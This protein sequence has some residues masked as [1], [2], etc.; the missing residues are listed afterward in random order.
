MSIVDEYREYAAECLK[1]AKVAKSECQRDTYLE[2]ASVWLQAAI[3]AD[4]RN[5]D[6][7]QISG[8][9]KTEAISR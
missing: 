4:K 7:D 8:R 6:S 5:I 2:M 9:G 3:I 1:W